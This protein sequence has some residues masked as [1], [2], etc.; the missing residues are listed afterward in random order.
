MF[1]FQ[2]SNKPWQMIVVLFAIAFLMIILSTIAGAYIDST[3]YRLDEDEL[4]GSIYLV[5][6]EESSIHS[7]KDHLLSNGWVSNRVDDEQ[8]EY[9]LLLVRHLSNHY[10][11]IDP[12]LITAMI[13]V[14]SKFDTNAENSGARGLMQLLETYHQERL[15]QFIEEDDRYSRDLFYEPRLNIMAG[16]D[17]MSYIL[18]AVDGDVNYALMWYN[19]GAVSACEMYE[20]SGIIS[21]Y[22]KVVQRLANELKQFE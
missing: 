11:N 16:M 18:G 6:R 10:T 13:A 15:I 22:S 2:M 5:S 3:Q 21:V 7:M 1:Q 8:L 9:I 20:N 14:E 17:Y 4:M 19:Q 12:N